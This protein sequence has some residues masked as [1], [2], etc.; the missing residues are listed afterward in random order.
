MA[1]LQR[2]ANT[3]RTARLR[4]DIDREQA[5]H[6]AERAD[7][8]RGEGLSD[9]EAWRRA[10]LQFGSPAAQIERTRDV[11]VSAWLDGALR[12][13]RQALRALRRTPG[14]TAT[15]VLTLAAG[16]G[17]NAA[18]FSAIDVVL[19]RPLPFPEPQRLVR[20]RQT[21]GVTGERDV[22]GARVQDWQRGNKTFATI[23]GF[24]TQDVS[25]TTGTEPQRVRRA[26]VL[27]HFFDVWAVHPAQGRGFT[28]AEHQLGG[29]FVAVISDR[30]WRTRLGATPA[31]LTQQVRAGDRAYAIVGVMPATFAFIDR[32]T[33]WWIP[34][35]TNAP[36]AQARE[37]NSTTTIGR[38]RAGVT[39]D[40]ARADIATLQTDL[41]RQYPTT[42][43]GLQPVLAGLGDSIVG[44]S[45]RSLWVLF[46]AVSILLLIACSNIAALLLSRG[47]ERAR[48]IAVRYS[49]GATRRAIALQL[50]TEAGVL[51]AAGGAAGIAVATFATAALRRLAPDVPRLDGAG[52]DG[53]ILLYIGTA[54]IVVTLLCGLLPAM[55]VSRWPVLR[56]TATA[57]VSNRHRLQWL[58]AG[59][60]VALAVT[61]LAGAGLLLRTA[62]ALDAVEAGFEAGRV[63]TFR[64][65]ASFGEERDYNRTVQ[66]INRTLDGLGAL[67]GV[68]ATATSS[69]LPGVRS[70]FPLEYT[71]V[72]GNVLAAADA[73]I[74]SPGYFAA[75]G[76]PLL[77]GELC[78]RPADAA[79]TTEVMV[80]R[81]FA[82]QYLQGRHPVGLHLAAA[83]P[84]RI[85]G[86]VEDSREY[87]LDRAPGPTVY[88]CFSAPTPFPF[89]LV[90]TDGDPASLTTAV[91]RT[92]FDL[93]PLRSV[94]EV[95]PLSDR[96]A[97][98]Y[99]EQRLR[100][101]LLMTFA[102]GALL[103]SCL[104]IYGT[105]SYITRLQRRDIGLRLALGATRGGILRLFVVQGLRVAAVATIA[106]LALSFGLTRTLSGMLY[107]VTPSD[108]A[109]LA[110][111]VTVVLAV[112][113]LAAL[114]PAARAALASPMRTLRDD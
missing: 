42:D 44:H 14:F 64:V 21:G 36:W 98:I 40:Q 45:R 75:L 107:G 3:L 34:E 84:D 38:L 22:A 61:L 59:V 90:R 55:R 67:P 68:T 112:A 104:G 72:E 17:A 1:R 106:G 109:T 73:R 88:S 102:V 6:L 86:V 111:V 78:R 39:I 12:N 89:F 56:H 49:L 71:I 8:L 69:L 95:L 28:A 57:R 10:R 99:A 19:L 5:F 80:N 62:A 16:I 35:S 87:G 66:R 105:L 43:R 20:I 113:T 94:Y 33:D 9:A 47:A 54:A 63:L 81:R 101:T 97:G 92:I 13:L 110:G 4:R 103:L 48:E 85:T 70:E 7:Q 74:V 82:E 58:L 96:I 93:E 24:V 15:V 108:P 23:S 114:V 52:L 77:A 51:A 25:D 76:I 29:P 11:N 18:V 50:L 83:A 37:F 30:Y 91:R 41:A 32:E 2:L 100:T 79:G 27:P 46:G 60:Q 26:T 31:V 53:R 65:S